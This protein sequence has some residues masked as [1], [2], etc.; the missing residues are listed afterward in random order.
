LDAVRAAAPDDDDLAAERVG[1]AAQLR[2]VGDERAP[3]FGVAPDVDGRLPGTVRS[4]HPS[5][6]LPAKLS[7]RHAA[8]LAPVF[9][10]CAAC[11]GGV[12]LAPL[13]AGRLFR[14]GRASIRAR[15]L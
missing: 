4:V 6:L 15:A 2:L 1:D 10:A 8:H 9:P 13:V 3:L 11:V 7:P 14:L 12:R 5:V